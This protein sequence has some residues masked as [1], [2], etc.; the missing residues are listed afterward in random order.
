VYIGR[1][2]STEQLSDE[3]KDK[4]AGACEGR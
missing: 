3:W 1:G 4:R 2:M